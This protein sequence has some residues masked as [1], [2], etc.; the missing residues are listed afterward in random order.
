MQDKTLKEW[1]DIIKIQEHWIG[2]CTG[3]NIDFQLIS[4]VP[5]YPKSV[6][7]WT[8]KPEYIENATFLA[9]SSNSLLAKIEKTESHNS[10]RKL[11][12]KVV[13]PFTN[14]ELPIYVTDKGNIL[15][16]FLQQHLEIICTIFYFTETLPYPDFRDDYLGIP[17]L[18]EADIEFCKTAGISYEAGPVYSAEELE[19]KRSDILRIAKE[20]NIGGYLVSSKLRDW[21]IS[22]QRYWGTPIPIVHCDKC[23]SQPVPRDDLPVTLPK[24]DRSSENKNLTLKDANEW[25]KTSC[26]KCKGPATRETDTM[27]TFVDSSWYFMRYIDP[28]NKKEMFSKE[29]AFKSLPVDLYIG[30]KE[31]GRNCLHFLI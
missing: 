11:N 19:E 12:A 4:D 14:E 25:L 23:G 27:D 3:T 31:H 10:I 15:V 16:R 8:D 6:T 30:G 26:P 20:R 21:L 5:G 17:C 9:I 28:K 22:R 18:S 29:E 7:L 13:N 24:L 1:R 2:Q